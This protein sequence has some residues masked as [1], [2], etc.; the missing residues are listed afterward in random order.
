MGHPEA[1]A[2]GGRPQLGREEKG[3]RDAQV[4]GQDQQA[5]RTPEQPQSMSRGMR[6]EG[7]LAWRCPATKGLP[8]PWATGEGLGEERG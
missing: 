1:A 7:A 6:E 3:N 4:G 5:S 2:W 8:S